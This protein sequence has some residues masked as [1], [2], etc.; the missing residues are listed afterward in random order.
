MEGERRRSRGRATAERGSGLEAGAWG[1]GTQL[2]GGG[3]AGPWRPWKE[4]WPATHLM[5]PPSEMPLT[6]LIL[7]LNPNWGR[8][9]LT[10]S[11]S[12]AKRKVSSSIPSQGAWLG[13]RFAP[14]W[15]VQEATHRCFFPPPFT[16]HFFKKNV[17]REGKG[18]REGAKHQC[19]VA[20]CTPPTGDLACKPGMFP[21]WESN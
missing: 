1:D 6:S 20:S 21:D 13:C 5:L 8:S 12:S 18:G 14:S 16:S 2:G 10:E 15:G 3:R 9:Q 17:F 7:I 19:V 11:A 4:P